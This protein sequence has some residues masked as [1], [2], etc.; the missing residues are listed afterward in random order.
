MN[1]GSV[2]AK[3]PPVFIYILHLYSGGGR[4]NTA[5]GR[6]GRDRGLRTGRLRRGW[7]KNGREE[8]VC[9]GLR[10]KRRPAAGRGQTAGRR[11]CAAGRPR[12]ADL[13]RRADG[14][15]LKLAIRQTANRPKNP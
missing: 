1:P 4:K 2:M 12:A 14:G 10:G 3:P 15:I 7:R 13:S 5:G 11:G 8:R 6:H 9:R